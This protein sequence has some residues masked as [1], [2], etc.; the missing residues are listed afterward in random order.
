MFLTSFRMFIH[1]M[2]KIIRG[3]DIMKCYY[4]ED[5]EAVAQCSCGVGLCKEC[6]NQ[7]KTP[8]CQNC[9]DDINTSL[10]KKAKSRVRNTHI[11]IVLM[12][13]VGIVLAVK[14]LFEGNGHNS[15]SILICCAIGGFLLAGFPAGWRTLDI[16]TSSLFMFLPIVG[17]IIY[18]FVKSGL[19]FI[20]GIVML[21][22]EYIKARK[23]IKDLS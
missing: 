20:F 19:A 13:I 9:V 21:P 1:F 11:I 16:V 17:W 7:Y 8:I 4:H 2:R 12:I 15:I 23:T 18:F 22:V 14:A 6:L 3:V 5:R 10:L